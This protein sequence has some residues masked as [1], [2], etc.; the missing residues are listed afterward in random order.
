MIRKRNTYM[1]KMV[2]FDLG[3]TLVRPAGEG[4]LYNPLFFRLF[5]SLSAEDLKSSLWQEAAAEAYRPLQEHPGMRDV[6]EQKRRFTEYYHSLLTRTGICG[7]IRPAELLAEDL[8]ENTENMKLLEGAGETL[9]ILRENGFHMAV[10][11]DTWPYIGKYLRDL[12][13]AHYFDHFTYSYKLGTVKPSP[14]MYQDALDACGFLPRECLFTDDRAGNLIAAE[15]FHINAVQSC[16]DPQC[17]RDPRFTAVEKPYDILPLL[18]L[19]A[20]R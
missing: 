17:V 15:R 7:D 2:F 11:S 1:I 9:R 13:I 14:M 16:A 3:W 18:G 6:A 12:G 20:L 10:I 8:C 4:W 5:P 19:Q